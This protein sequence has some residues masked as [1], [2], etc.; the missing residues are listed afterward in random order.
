MANQLRKAN[1]VVHVANH[2]VDALTFLKKTTFS[3]N[4]EPSA[5]ALSVVLMD[6]EM[7][8]YCNS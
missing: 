8:V 3:K 5:V 1:C 2:G 4:C 6:L 7:P